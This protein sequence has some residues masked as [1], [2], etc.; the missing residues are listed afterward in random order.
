M[1]IKLHVNGKKKSVDV[2]PMKRLLDTL[3]EELALT[4]T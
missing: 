3:R 4:G 1:K 2:A